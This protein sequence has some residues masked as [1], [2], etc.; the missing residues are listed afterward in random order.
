[1]ASFINSKAETDDNLKFEKQIF[2]KIQILHNIY[3][4]FHIKRYKKRK[5]SIYYAV[6]AFFLLK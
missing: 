6:L 1:M 5:M 3:F 4:E 2:L